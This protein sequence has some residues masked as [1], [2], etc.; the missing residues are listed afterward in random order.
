MCCF[1]LLAGAP[2]LSL[3]VLITTTL[4]TWA[5]LCSGS[6]AAPWIFLDFSGWHFAAINASAMGRWAAGAVIS[7]AAALALRAAL[8]VWLPSVIGQRRRRLKPWAV[9]AFDA[10]ADALSKTITLLVVTPLLAAAFMSFSSSAPAEVLP[11]VEEPGMISQSLGWLL[12][13]EFEAPED[14]QWRLTSRGGAFQ[15]SALAQAQVL[16][17]LVGTPW[18]VVGLNRNRSVPASCSAVPVAAGPTSPPDGAA[19]GVGPKMRVLCEKGPWK[20]IDPA[21]WLPALGRPVATD[22]SLD[23]S[24]TR[25][26]ADPQ[27]VPMRF[28]EDLASKV[29]RVKD[30][31]WDRERLDG[32]S[33][34][35]DDDDERLKERPTMRMN[36]LAAIWREL[37]QR[38][39]QEL[40]MIVPCLW[41]QERQAL[42]N[43]MLIATEKCSHQLEVQPFAAD[44]DWSA[45]V[46]KRLAASGPVPRPGVCE[47]LAESYSWPQAVQRERVL[48]VGL[49]NFLAHKQWPGAIRLARD[50]LWNLAQAAAL[51][52]HGPAGTAATALHAMADVWPIG[53]AES[54]D[55][56]TWMQ[57]GS[58]DSLLSSPPDSSSSSAY[59][60][61]YSSFGGGRGHS[62]NG[63][64]SNSSFRLLQQ[65]RRGAARSTDASLAEVEFPWDAFPGQT[66]A[67]DIVGIPDADK[68]TLWHA[69]GWSLALPGLAVFAEGLSQL[70]Q[71]AQNPPLPAP[72]LFPP[73]PHQ[74]T[75]V[76]ALWTLAFSLRWPSWGIAALAVAALGALA[77]AARAGINVHRPMPWIVLAASGLCASYLADSIAGSVS[78]IAGLGCLLVARTWAAKAASLTRAPPGTRVILQAVFLA[79]AGSLLFLPLGWMWAAASLAATAVAVSAHASTL[80]RHALEAIAEIRSQELHHAQAYDAAA[81]QASAVAT[82]VS[83][84]L[85]ALSVACVILELVHGDPF[86]LQWKLARVLPLTLLYVS[87]VTVSI[88]ATKGL[89]CAPRSGI[90]SAA[91]VVLVIAASA[92]L[93]AGTILAPLATMASVWAGPLVLLAVACGNAPVSMLIIAGGAFVAVGSISK[94][95]SAFLDRATSLKA[96]LEAEETPAPSEGGAPDADK[97]RDP[98]SAADR[99]A[100][101]SARHAS[102][103]AWQLSVVS[104]PEAAQL[105]TAHVLKWAETAVADS[106]AENRTAPLLGV[107][108]RTAIEVVGAAFAASA[109]SE[110]AA[111]GGELL[112]RWLVVHAWAQLDAAGD[113]T[114][115]CEW[116]ATVC[117]GLVICAVFESVY[118]LLWHNL[119]PIIQLAVRQPVV[120]LEQP[121]R[122]FAI[123]HQP[124]AVSTYRRT[125]AAI[126]VSLGLVKP[127]RQVSAR[128][129]RSAGPAASTDAAAAGRVGD[130]G[131]GT[132]PPAAGVGPGVAHASGTAAPAAGPC[133]GS[134]GHPTRAEDDGAAGSA[135]P[136][137]GRAGVPER[138]SSPLFSARKRRDSGA[139]A[140]DAPRPAVDRLAQELRESGMHWQQ[141]TVELEAVRAATAPAALEAADL[142]WGALKFDLGPILALADSV[143]LTV[144]RSLPA[145]QARP[146]ASIPGPPEIGRQHSQ[147]ST[148]G[149]LRRSAQAKWL[150]WA[151]GGL[152]PS[153]SA[154]AAGQGP[155]AGSE[156][157]SLD[158]LEAMEV[159]PWL[160]SE[161][162]ALQAT[163]VAR[164]A[165]DVIALAGEV[166][167]EWL[168]LLGEN[169][170]TSSVVFPLTF[171]AR[172]KSGAEE[173]SLAGVRLE[174]SLL[175]RRIAFGSIPLPSWLLRRSVVATL[176]ARSLAA[177]LV[178]DSVVAAASPLRLPGTRLCLSA[179][180][181]GAQV[182][183][184]HVLH[185]S[186]QRLLKAGRARPAVD[187]ATEPPSSRTQAA[188]A[189]RAAA[190]PS[191][192]EPLPPGFVSPADRPVR[193]AI[194]LEAR[195]SFDAILTVLRAASTGI[196]FLEELLRER[197]ELDRIQADESKQA[198]L[199]AEAR[200]IERADR[201]TVWQRLLTALQLRMLRIGRW[202]SESAGLGSWWLGLLDLAAVA[203][204]ITRFFGP[205]NSSSDTGSDGRSRAERLKN[206]AERPSLLWLQET[207]RG[208]SQ[209]SAW[210]TPSQRAEATKDTACASVAKFVSRKAGLHADPD[211]VLGRQLLAD[212]SGELGRAW[213]QAARDRREG[214][215]SEA[216]SL[217]GPTGDEYRATLERHLADAAQDA[218]DDDDEATSK[219][220]VSSGKRAARRR[221]DQQLARQASAEDTD[222]VFRPSATWADVEFAFE[223]VFSLLVAVPKTDTKSLDAH[224]ETADDDYGLYP[225]KPSSVFQWVRAHAARRGLPDFVCWLE[226]SIARLV[227]ALV[228]VI[229]SVCVALLGPAGQAADL[230]VLPARALA[231][232]TQ[233]VLSA[234][235]FVAQFPRMGHLAVS[236]EE[237]RAADAADK[238][239]RER[240]DILVAHGGA[241]PNRAGVTTGTG[242]EVCVVIATPESEGSIAGTLGLGDG[243]NGAVR[244][245]LVQY[246]A[247]S[248]SGQ[249]GAW[250]ASAQVD[251]HAIATGVHALDSGRRAAIAAD[252]LAVAEDGA[253]CAALLEAD[254]ERT[255]QRLVTAHRTQ[256]GLWEALRPGQ[257]YPRYCELGPRVLEAAIEEDSRQRAR[258]GVAS[259]L[260]LV[261]E[262]P[263]AAA[264]LLDSGR[265]VPAPAPE[266]G[267]DAD[268]S[269]GGDRPPP[270]APLESASAA[271]SAARQAVDAPAPGSSEAGGGLAVRD[272]AG[273]DGFPDWESRARAAIAAAWSARRAL[274]AHPRAFVPRSDFGAALV[275]EV[276]ALHNDVNEWI[277]PKRAPEATLGILAWMRAREL[278][279]QAE[280][281]RLLTWA[282][283]MVEY[284]TRLLEPS[285]H[286]LEHAAAGDRGRQWPALGVPGAVSQLVAEASQSSQLFVAFATLYAAESRRAQVS[287]D[288]ET[289]D[290]LRRAE[291]EE[292]FVQH[293]RT[294]RLSASRAPSTPLGD[295]VPQC[296]LA[297]QPIAEEPRVLEA[298]P[299]GLP[300]PQPPALWAQVAAWFRSFL[301]DEQAGAVDDTFALLA[302]V[303]LAHRGVNPQHD[304]SWTAGF[305]L[306]GW[307]AAHRTSLLLLGECALREVDAM[308]SASQSTLF[309]DESGAP[310]ALLP[311]D[312]VAD[313]VLAGGMQ[314]GLEA[315]AALPLVGDA[316]RATAVLAGVSH[317]FWRA[318]AARMS[319]GHSMTLALLSAAQAFLQSEPQACHHLDRALRAASEADPPGPDVVAPVSVG[320]SLAASLLQLLR[321]SAAPALLNQA[322]SLAGSAS[323]IHRQSMAFLPHAGWRLLAH[324]LASATVDAEAARNLETAARIGSRLLPRSPQ[325]RARDAPVQAAASMA[326]T[327][328]IAGARRGRDT[329]RPEPILVVPPRTSPP[330][331][332]PDEAD[333]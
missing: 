235:K 328:A 241:R 73:A 55:G 290:A 297:R 332:P 248:W 156:R 275:D 200:L 4:G 98:S 222:W 10:Q 8:R 128:R 226:A 71:A 268:P 249:L 224:V 257:Q 7:A 155:S 158:V 272:G 68:V 305:D 48:T 231:L 175:S 186:T 87:V 49:R 162:E 75:V 207:L 147:A 53:G 230:T 256:V 211:V 245:P 83:A 271:V 285:A 197:T 100:L 79:G 203:T 139:S 303:L 80:R 176:S 105:A 300:E 187:S 181:A 274:G 282:M 52:K 277:D 279:P 127:R 69:A 317:E 323:R 216:P 114:G 210:S 14:H 138:L 108:L 174:A 228:A 89:A 113:L 143:G 43:R 193:R 126:A 142:A 34:D 121:A 307:A 5:Y 20:G 67:M 131:A 188:P 255:F 244:I 76:L 310:L 157:E 9:Q 264:G 24:A 56:A 159:A 81:A 94:C 149:T 308:M 51:A 180:E 214:S 45:C 306:V 220:W 77:W 97:H 259:D 135:P 33:D 30:R 154:A 198:A 202:Y 132:G 167:R 281:T 35:N 320:N 32:K 22:L 93:C 21:A 258:Q 62:L 273:L 133:S 236:A 38:S 144:P 129:A 111:R 1:A 110:W 173:A 65:I 85:G 29:L 39:R 66:A 299:A 153:A 99:A 252:A 302:H 163:S 183:L 242:A 160:L 120:D 209:E 25:P 330:R 112:R 46:L 314:V 292:E 227:T 23:T 254:G 243:L 331:S 96:A 267:A 266:P 109:I 294:A 41:M 166:A 13:W 213:V 64:V 26:G 161:C 316:E 293:T 218:R 16:A 247:G 47:E 150:L 102:Q 269:A 170:N 291:A 92:L 164:P 315:L 145:G 189:S 199:D 179:T 2:W 325:H 265:G 253:E 217:L 116:G 313:L 101:R 168:V 123:R 196:P 229:T 287:F 146:E 184:D 90:P 232:W 18:A 324:S 212:K 194:M 286:E 169:A 27:L 191:L 86:T 270:A 289:E 219:V 104:F 134:D 119:V 185:A 263:E 61:S 107:D 261:E 125:V 165:F 118:R 172:F 311:P 329:S 17:G 151:M 95:I 322:A 152:V 251:D 63:G 190:A 234:R 88:L 60:S 40:E 295:L 304:L 78:G 223:R 321:S 195:V 318:R 137:P 28:L 124:A 36:V 238:R 12:G 54:V 309:E 3:V 42:Q 326:A 19:S 6:L 140:R 240:L 136:T 233:A 103:R 122:L 84:L 106:E 205:R 301:S 204:R 206:Q 208:A 296:P 319:S 141:R 58:L 262:R 177:C 333:M 192:E 250:A 260:R 171:L 117:C 215:G 148:A 312:P 31:V 182:T 284:A 276:V 278:Q 70:W 11:P 221:R 115:L 59:S 239:T 178:R 237:T 44:E 15:G 225:P 280:R 288:E 130:D 327:A 37:D 72:G 246:M 57:P 201:S 91:V 283:D 82:P 74:S 298:A 50:E